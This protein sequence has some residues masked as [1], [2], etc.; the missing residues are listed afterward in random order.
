M[1]EREPPSPLLKEC[2]TSVFSGLWLA[3][4]VELR[5]QGVDVRRRGSLLRHLLLFI[6][7]GRSICFGLALLLRLELAV[8]LEPDV[9]LPSPRHRGLRLLLLSRVRLGLI[10]RVPLRLLAQVVQQPLP[11]YLLRIWDFLFRSAGHG[12]DTV[13]VVVKARLAEVAPGLVVRVQQQVVAADD[14]PAPGPFR[15]AIVTFILV[16]IIL[17]V[18]GSLPHLLRPALVL[19]VVVV[20]QTRRQG[21]PVAADVLER[22]RVRAQRHHLVPSLPCP[23]LRRLLLLLIMLLRRLRRLLLRWRWRWRL[24]RRRRPRRQL[25]PGGPLR[26][27]ARRD[28]HADGFVQLGVEREEVL[29]QVEKVTY[30]HLQEHPRELR[31]VIA[32]PVLDIGEDE[33]AHDLRGVLGGPSAGHDARDCGRERRVGDE[34]VPGLGLLRLA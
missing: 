30:L 6:R 21:W 22:H 12:V 31:G 28:K 10:R 23:R 17:K 15:L 8:L 11:L 19:L 3:E 20:P 4:V 25:R 24:L 27:L 1:E 26:H 18:I 2:F 34:V 14:H 7:S 9:R 32:V 5:Q 16:L 13:A 29:R 33:L